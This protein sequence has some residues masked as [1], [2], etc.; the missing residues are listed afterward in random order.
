MVLVSMDVVALREDIDRLTRFTRD[1]RDR[2][3]VLQLAAARAQL[4]AHRTSGELERHLDTIDRL[5]EELTVRVDLME[6]ADSADAGG[7]LTSVRTLDLPHGDSN[8]AVRTQLGHQLG[9]AAS[10]ISDPAAAQAFT[11]RTSRYLDDPLVMAGLYEKLGAADLLNLVT[12]SSRHTTGENVLAQQLKD[13][14]STADAA[15]MPAQRE[16]FAADLVEMTAAAVRPGSLHATAPQALAYLLRDAEYSAELLGGVA[17]G[18]DTLERTRPVDS[19]LPWASA[20]DPGWSVITQARQWPPLHDPIPALMSALANNPVAAFEFFSGPDKQDRAAHYFQAREGGVG[21]IAHAADIAAT[22]FYRQ[23]DPRAEQSAW[24]ASAAVYHFGARG[25]I[26][27]GAKPALGHLLAFHLRG[28]RQVTAG[29]DGALGTLPAESRHG[30][31]VSPPIA[32]FFRK[33]LAT[34]LKEVMTDPKAVASIATAMNYLSAEELSYG[35]ER[36]TVQDGYA[37]ESAATNSSKLTGFL[38]EAI[39]V[40]QDAALAEQE[41]SIQMLIGFG[42][43]VAGLIPGVGSLAEYGF[44]QAVSSARQDAIARWENA[45]VQSSEGQAP[46]GEPSINSASASNLKVAVALALMHHGHMLTDDS[47]MTDDGEMTNSTAF[48]WMRGG[49]LVPTVLDDARARDRMLVWIHSMDAGP[50]VHYRNVIDGQVA[51]GHVEY[52]RS[53]ST[54][55]TSE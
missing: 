22:A 44:E 25:G 32:D 47:S 42:S 39:G 12:A 52:H 10:E 36:W 19:H 5:R 31:E 4:T 55:R 46:D 29:T 53:S 7:S 9:R 26:D 14:L 40:G 18:L 13:G 16:A 54:V 30:E 48:P 3:P 50:M 20:A 17:A 45:A 21:A 33:R 34:V 27:E 49:R 2:W 37:L 28:V 11:E 23:G 38:L 41:A 1:A 8:D 15:W 24:I 6:L 35:A 51:A 43:G